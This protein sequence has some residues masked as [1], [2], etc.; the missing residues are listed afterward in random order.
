[1]ARKTS[2]VK[3]NSVVTRTK[4]DTD[5]EI[6]RWKEIIKNIYL[7]VHYDLGSSCSRTGIMDK[8]SRL[9]EDLDPAER[10]LNQHW[11]WD[12]I[13]RSVF[14]KQAD[15]LQGIYFFEDELR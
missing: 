8:S 10:P 1:M 9:S 6:T 14:I 15:V 13:L 3:Y 11:S 4:L 2:P 7:P 12:R 5:W